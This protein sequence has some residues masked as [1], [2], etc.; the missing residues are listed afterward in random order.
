VISKCLVLMV[1]D[2]LHIKN[3][4]QNLAIDI[5]YTLINTENYFLSKY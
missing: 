5:N 4:K 1:L 2:L 3:W